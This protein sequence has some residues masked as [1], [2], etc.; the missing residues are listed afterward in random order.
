M[1]SVCSD[2][3]VRRATLPGGRRLGAYVITLGFALSGCG[4]GVRP[5]DAGPSETTD[6]YEAEKRDGWVKVCSDESSDTVHV[7]HFGDTST[8]GEP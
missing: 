8:I 5:P 4:G 3:H 7:Y 1:S 6:C 2:A